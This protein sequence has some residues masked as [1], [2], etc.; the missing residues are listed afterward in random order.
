VVLCIAVVACVQSA[1]AQEPQCRLYKVQS[2]SINISK[3]PRGDAVYIDT[4]D[5]T[6]VVCVTRERKVGERNWGFVEHKLLTSDQRK[7]VAGWANLALLQRLA[8]AESPS[9]RGLTASPPAAAA[10]PAPAPATPTPAPAGQDVVR[11]KE[12]LTSGPYPVNGSSLEQLVNGI[13]LF[14]PIEGL[15]EAVWKKNCNACHKWDQRTLCEQAASYV[16]NPKSALRGSH[17]YGGAEKVAMM[18]WA[19]TGCQ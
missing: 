17:P 12:P 8:E 13:P 10:A 5:N 7:P 15:E 6:D 14:P 4:L 18:Q 19:K 9:A 1:P 2:N 3:E 16:K 11:F